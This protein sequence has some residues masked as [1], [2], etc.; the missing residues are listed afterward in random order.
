LLLIT[1]TLLLFP[2]GK[3]ALETKQVGSWTVEI[4]GGQK[5]IAVTNGVSLLAALG[6]NNI[7]L[8]SACGGN[9][10]CGYCKVKVLNGGGIVTPKEDPLLSEQEKA[11]GVR[12]SCQ[13]SVASDLFISLPPSILSVKRFTGKLVCKQ[14]LTPDIARLHIELLRPGSM[15][16]IA[17]QFVQIRSQPY[18]GKEAVLRNYSISS[19]SSNKNHIDLMVRKVPGGI[20]ST[21]AFDHLKEGDQ[22]YFSGPFGDFK[23][24]NASAPVLFIA[25]GSGMGPIWSMIND[26][27]EKGSDRKAFYFFGT[28]TQGDLFL[29]EE[30]FGL[31]KELAAFTFI[32]ALS[33]EP[34]ESDWQGERGLVTQ[35]VSRYFPDCSEFE[36]YVC[37][38]SGLIDACKKILVKGG[39]AEDKIF[40]DKFV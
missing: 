15:D 23:L 2:I 1:K 30:L 14:L 33:D 21:W 7:V 28:R 25:G 20:C 10:R 19:C 16:F 12:L 27:K 9:A 17:G 6:R 31:Q 22:I 8:P 38:S 39:M 34:A 37:G 13:V 4:N 26:M 32:P 40:F 36:A 3:D 18:S 11:S 24:S 29:T 35:V 5:K